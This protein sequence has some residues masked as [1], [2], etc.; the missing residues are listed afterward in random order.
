MNFAEARFWGF[1]LAGLGLIALLRFALRPVLGIRRDMFDKVALV[2]LGLFLLLCVSWVTCVIFLVV[3]VGSYLGLKWLLSYD[4]KRRWHGLYLLIP[5]QLLP[6]AY[7]KYANFAI[8]QVL[9][10]DFPTL[11]NLIIPVGISFYSFQKVAFVIDTL[12][13]KQPLPRLLD[14]LNFAGFFPQIVA[15]PI[16]RRRDLLPQME[17]FCFRW[18]AQNINE[19]V[20]WIAVGLFFKLCL[21]DNLAAFFDGSSTANAYLIWLANL[22]FGLRIYYDFAGYSLI[23]F[24]LARCLGVKLTLNFCSPYCANSMVEFWRRWHVTLS[25]WFRDYLYIPLGG[26]RVRWWGFNIALV[27]VVSGVWHGAGWNFV[28]WGAMHGTALI[29]NRI[30]G[31]KLKLP[32]FPAWL[33]TMA[34]VFCAWLG[35]YETRTGILAL[36][37]KTLLTPAGYNLAALREAS[38]VFTTANGFVLMCFLILA[39]LALLVEWLSV[40]RRD[41]PYYFLCRPAVLVGLIILTVALAPGKSNGFIYFAF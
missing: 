1:L 10:F 19:G 28:F 5:L 8:N 4:E 41:E 7:Y 37:L 13:L 18:S 25:Q 32:A 21:A 30:A 23:A 3:A 24:G 26:G 33:L 12:V 31:H 17:R 39:G 29:V 27:F 14:Y 36:K 6:L 11:Q 9:G 16:E 35:F 40:A 2:S 15:G 20:S 22:L 34:T 38:L